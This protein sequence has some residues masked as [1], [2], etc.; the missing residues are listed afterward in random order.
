MKKEL[1][2]VTNAS[3]ESGVGSRAYETVSRVASDDQIHAN[4]VVLD[5]ETRELTCFSPSPYKGVRLPEL[6]GVL[7]AKSITWVRLARELPTFDIYDLSNQTL[8]FIAK[9]RHPS[10]VTVHDLI[11]LT[12]PQDSRARLVH[13]YLLS[14]ISNAD[15]IV[16]VS[17]YTKQVLI[18]RLGMSASRIIVIPNGV[19]EQ[20]AQVQN[21]TQTIAYKQLLLDYGINN[22]VPIILYVGSEHPRKNMETLFKVIAILKQQYP[23]ILLLKIGDAGL[24]SGRLKTLET[25]DELNLKPNIKLLGNVPAERMNELYNI[26]DALV[27]PSKLEGFGMPPLEAM[28]AGCPVVCSNATSLPEVVGNGGL[29]H[30]PDNAEAF[31]ASVVHILTNSEF[32]NNLVL[33]GKKQ[34]ALFSWDTAARAMLDVYHEFV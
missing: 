20:Y 8:S 11:E 26:A 16:S 12:D 2:I 6:P 28:A 21:F 22:R 19:N 24:R 4:L 10:I 7:R 14:G 15:R 29:L 18:E 3:R 9:K 5:G 34:A 23:D 1:A 25:I 27:F 33:R 17:Q 30:N 13:R 32:K 31:A